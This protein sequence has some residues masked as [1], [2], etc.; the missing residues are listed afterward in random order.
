[1]EKLGKGAFGEVFMAEKISSKK[2]VAVKKVK[3]SKLNRSLRTH[4]VFFEKLILSQLKNSGIVKLLQ[5]FQ[6]QDYFYIVTE[7][8]SKQT[9]NYFIKNNKF[10]SQTEVA[11]FAAQLINILQYLH[12]KG[13]VHRD[14]KPENIIVKPDG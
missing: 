12:Q 10:L 7:F 6:D 2:K 11:S 5:T 9:L 14:I 3:K 13:F 1:M 8:Q 4:T